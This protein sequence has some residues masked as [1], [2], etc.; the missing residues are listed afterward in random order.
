[1]KHV[2]T[3]GRRIMIMTTL[4][5][6]CL[7]H[8]LIAYKAVITVPIAD[9]VGAP[10]MPALYESSTHE[11]YHHIPICGATYQPFVACPRLHQA[12]Y[13]QYVDVTQE[14]GDQV[15]ITV[16][17]VF[18]VTERSRAHHNQFWTLRSH[19]TSVHALQEQGINLQTFPQP[20]NA[21][22]HT[23]PEHHIV[24]L[25][26]PLHDKATGLTFSAGTRFVMVPPS[27]TRT[28]IVSVYRY[29]TMRRKVGILLVPKKQCIIGSSHLSHTQ[30]IERF[31]TLL[32]E[33]AHQPDGVIP[34][35]WGG[36]SYVALSHPSRFSEIVVP[37]MQPYSYFVRP[38]CTQTPKSGVDCTGLACLAAQCCGIPYFLKN[39]TTV[40]HYLQP[41]A[42][43][44]SIIEGDIIWVPKHIMI[45]SD[46]K[47]NTLIE[48]RHYMHGYG[49]VHEVPLSKV[50]KN[51]NTY[52]DLHQ[53]YIDKKPLE[54]L[55]I[56]GTCKDTFTEFKILHIASVWDTTNA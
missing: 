50:F 52:A 27:K 18:Y 19:V 40:A 15:C 9:L 25:T 24:T 30:R 22:T 21:A 4:I 8:Q 55:D 1:M 6:A 41:V 32:K 36:C 23:V 47:K 44:E 14:R 16:P 46:L 7:S 34:Y 51:I 42:A 38:D 3:R 39:S 48:A 29:D 11:N 56:K 45:V 53:A 28:D 26:K 5:T 17:N 33:W 12:L 43:H 10:L 20:I 37:T 35:V 49:L 54:R 13:N 31:V 2:L